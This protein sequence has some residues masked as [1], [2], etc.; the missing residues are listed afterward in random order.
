VQPLKANRLSLSQQAQ[1]YLLDCIESGAFQ[2]GEQL[3]SEADL[4]VQLGISRGTLREA[5]LNLERGG[6]IVRKHGVGT[7]VAGHGRRLQ[8]GLERLESVLELAV[9]QGVQLR[10]QALQ[11][12]QE[13][14][15]PKLADQLQV[16]PGVPLTHIQRVI[17][18]DQTP[19]AFM[20][21]VV[22]SSILAPADVDQGFDGS[23]LDLLRQ[24]LAQNIHQALAHIVAL[25][26]D[27][28]LADKL[29]VKPGQALL[30]LEE[31]LFDDQGGIVEYS[32]NYFVPDFCDFHVLRR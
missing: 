27:A 31:T 29:K 20:L 2:P 23:V 8:G 14:A 12:T 21:D 1:Q 28:F 5:L 22:P 9:C 7:F 25:N 19:M 11:V 16:S 30:L 17:V 32:R 18:V 26:A 3:P 24:K 4:A 6:L 10:C 13:P 15:S